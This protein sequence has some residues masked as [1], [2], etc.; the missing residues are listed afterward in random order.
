MPE[1]HHGATGE[2]KLAIDS[3]GPE[4]HGRPVGFVSYGGRS[5]GLI[6]VEQLRT[7]LAELHTASA[8]DPVSFHGGRAAFDEAGEPHD[9]VTAAAQLDVL[10]AQ[11]EWWAEALGAARRARPFPG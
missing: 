4:W 7:V 10:L 9:P 5:G 2:L 1:Y 6:A 8:R 3:V 11:L